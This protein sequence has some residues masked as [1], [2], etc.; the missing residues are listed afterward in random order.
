M[1]GAA[2]HS[3]QHPPRGEGGDSLAVLGPVD[4]GDG[5]RVEPLEGEE[6]FVARR[7]DAVG[8]EHLADMVRRPRSRIGVEGLVGDGSGAGRQ[9]GEDGGAGSST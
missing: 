9:L 3:P 8:D 2:S 4:G 7:E 1:V 5:L 6:L